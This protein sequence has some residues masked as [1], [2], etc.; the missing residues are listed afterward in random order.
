MLY[1]EVIVGNKTRSETETETEKASI[2]AL[3][4]FKIFPKNENV[5]KN[6]N[7]GKKC[8]SKEHN[9]NSD[10]PLTPLSLS[11]SLNL[12]TDNTKHP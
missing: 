1:L 9:N 4:T 7:F 8:P 3:F 10:I 5:G 2:W 6:E 11:L 12:T